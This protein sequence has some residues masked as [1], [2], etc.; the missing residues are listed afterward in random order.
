MNALFAKFITTATIMEL[1]GCYGYTNAQG[2]TSWTRVAIHQ[3]IC[4]ARP[5]SSVGRALGF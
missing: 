5:D 1:I 3:P 2:Q 4:S